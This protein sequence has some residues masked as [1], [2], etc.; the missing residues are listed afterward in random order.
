M[1]CFEKKVADQTLG[2]IIPNIL[3]L[4]NS[5]HQ[6]LSNFL[7]FFTVKKGKSLSTH[8]STGKFDG[9]NYPSIGLT[10]F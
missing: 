6:L 2:T 7:I 4:N 3:I 8:K 10:R 1:I 5:N 9:S